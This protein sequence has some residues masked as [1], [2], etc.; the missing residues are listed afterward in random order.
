MYLLLVRRLDA[1]TH[2]YIHT[3][4]HTYII[5][6]QVT[7]LLARVRERLTEDTVL[8][9][10]ENTFELAVEVSIDDIPIFPRMLG[11][12]NLIVSEVVDVLLSAVEQEVGTPR[13]YIEVCQHQLA[14]T[15]RNM[16]T[17]FHKAIP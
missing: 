5:C 7:E 3:Y 6:I 13:A 10:L 14:L 1:H 4:I 11:G 8:Q 9:I 12:T 17:H 15:A 16:S 2:K